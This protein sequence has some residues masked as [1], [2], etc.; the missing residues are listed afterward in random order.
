MTTFR[1]Q[2]DVETPELIKALG[3]RHLL[4]TE[5]N[6]VIDQIIAQHTAPGTTYLIRTSDTHIVPRGTSERNSKV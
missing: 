1:L 2:L 6:R 5:L 3:L 4:Q